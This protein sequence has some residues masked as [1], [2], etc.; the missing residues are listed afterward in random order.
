MGSDGK[1]R[2]AVGVGK[3]DVSVRGPD[4]RSGEGVKQRKGGKG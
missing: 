2:T 1:G 4:G 3:S